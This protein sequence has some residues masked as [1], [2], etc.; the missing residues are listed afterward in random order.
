MVPDLAGFFPAVFDYQSTH[1]LSGLITHCVPIGL[2]V[3]Y[4]YHAVLKRP[5][6]DLLPAAASER[7]RPWTEQPID[8]SLRSVALSAACVAFGAA[9]HVL[10][11]SFTHRER[12]GVEVVPWLQTVVAEHARRPVHLFSVLQ[13]GSSVLLLPPLLIGFAWWVWRQP[14][15]DS[16]LERARLPHSVSWTVV[17]LLIGGS[18]IY[19]Q[20]MRESNPG[21]LWIN[22]LRFAVKHGSAV[23]LVVMVIYC[24]GM[25]FV[26]WR[27]SDAHSVPEGRLLDS[28]SNTE[29]EN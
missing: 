25:H 4:F 2:V 20:L 5:L 16:P 21:L 3:Y 15:D 24:V 10:W 26:W 14:R 6:V 23:A 18:V 27:E 8:F 22:A 28:S 19:F 13:H 29:P 9:T 7:L 12:W 11:D 17:G 1:S